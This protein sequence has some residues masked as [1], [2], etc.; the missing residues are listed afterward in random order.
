MLAY[1]FIP[2]I[3][4][5]KR[6]DVWVSEN[7]APASQQLHSGSLIY[8]LILLLTIT[9]GTLWIVFH[10]L[11]YNLMFLIFNY[12]VSTKPIFHVFMLYWLLSINITQGPRKRKGFGL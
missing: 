3:I 12:A 11:K 1:S 2:S 9:F 4:R 10:Y 8:V 5:V 6:F 7:V